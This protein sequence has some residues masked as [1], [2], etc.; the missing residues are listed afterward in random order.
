MSEVDPRHSTEPSGVA[1]KAKGSAT[2]VPATTEK[3]PLKTFLLRLVPAVVPVV[4]TLVAVT[5]TLREKLPPFVVPEVRIQTWIAGG[6]ALAL[7]VRSISQRR[8]PSA[9]AV[10]ELFA[11]VVG[12]I[13][14]LEILWDGAEMDMSK[15][16]VRAL[17]M[18]AAGSVLAY[19]A[20]K[21]GVKILLRKAR[22][23]IAQPVV[24]MSEQTGDRERRL[25]DAEAEL[26]S[27]RR[28]VRKLGRSEIERWRIAR[29]DRHLR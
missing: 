12:V 13:G 2:V 15:V 28:K 7:A 20:A 4:F 29:R 14:G 8:A 19:V 5:S 3:S 27:L 23:Q 17:E 1:V 26:T 22:H 10:V 21:G 9:E 11:Y 16:G 18:E 25:A 6:V 24:A